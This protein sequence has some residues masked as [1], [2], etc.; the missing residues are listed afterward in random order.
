MPEN[1]F[2]DSSDP[3]PGI[4]GEDGSGCGQPD[5]DGVVALK[6]LRPSTIYPR[7]GITSMF[8]CRPNT[9]SYGPSSVVRPS[10]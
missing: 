8:A 9:P 4:E 3:S 2:P 5:F 6:E 7:C 10:R 1:K